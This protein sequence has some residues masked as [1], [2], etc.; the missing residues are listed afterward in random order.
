MGFGHVHDLDSKKAFN[1]TFV[2][3]KKFGGKTLAEIINDHVIASE[4]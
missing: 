1:V 2:L 3:E 4:H